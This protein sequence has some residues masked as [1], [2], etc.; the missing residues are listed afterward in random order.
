MLIFSKELIIERLWS[1][2][3]WWQTQKID[4]YYQSMKPRLY[5]KLFYP[6]ATDIS[7]SRAVVLMG[8]RRVGKTVMLF[9]T[10]QQLIK[11]GVS[12]RKICFISVETPIFNNV[13]LEQLFTYA[14]EASG[15][16]DT[17]GWYIIFDEI[18]YFKTWEV[19]LK[20][21]VDR[22]K[23]SKFIVSGSA[24]AALKHASIESGAGRFT[25]FM[26]PPLTFIEYV[27]LQNLG[28][29]IQPTEMEWYGSSIDFV[30]SHNIDELNEHF[31]DYLNYG[32]YP[33]AIFSSVV[34][35][36][37][38]RHILTDIIDKVLLKDLPSLY[39][40]RDVREL[41]SLF[42]TLA[43]HSGNETSYD[44][45]SQNTKIDKIT[46]KKYIDY[47]EASF[48][49]RIIYRID[50]NAKKFQRANYFKIYLTNP[51]LRSALFTFLK[52]DDEF[53]GS[54]VETA[55]FAQW[56]HRDKIIPYYARWQGGEVD[57]I[58]LDE[59]TF[60]PSWAIEIK[61]TNDNFDN[62][63]K[64]RSLYTFCERNNLQEALVTTKTKTGRKFTHNNIAFQFVP[65]A[66]YAYNVGRN[67]LITKLSKL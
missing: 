53:L 49:I 54:M 62:P 58:K 12:P 17:E 47:L 34:R 32:G 9:Q 5:F 60:K 39:G 1:D 37:P 25:D 3:P 64:L 16:V 48:L 23:Q 36:D 65:A 10:I 50:D 35:S 57:M 11:D 19:H 14:R 27:E 38:S 8:P 22:H 42:T 61:W 29:L 33:E 24:A 21:M 41:Y 28:H 43:Y 63:G 30:K 15:E 2:N 51:A 56:M 52:P 67:T 4:K 55:I 66:L 40:I 46:I 45:L 31:L 7:L 44:L 13:D 59:A 26:L 18:Q 20:V 6:L